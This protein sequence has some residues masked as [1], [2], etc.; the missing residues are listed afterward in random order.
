MIEASA[1]NEIQPPNETSSALESPELCVEGSTNQLVSHDELIPSSECLDQC[2]NSLNV[3]NNDGEMTTSDI[4]IGIFNLPTCEVFDPWQFE[5]YLPHSIPKSDQPLEASEGE[6]YNCYARAVQACDHTE[7]QG[8]VLEILAGMVGRREDPPPDL[9]MNPASPIASESTINFWSNTNDTALDSSLATSN[10]ITSSVH[11]LLPGTCPSWQPPFFFTDQAPYS[12]FANDSLHPIE[13]WGKTYKTATHLFEAL[14]Y[15]RYD[16]DRVEEIRGC[17]NVEEVRKLSTKLVR[18]G[19]APA[20]WESNSF[21]MIQG[22]LYAKFT[23]HPSLKRLL[24]NTPNGPL[25]YHN[26]GDGYWGSGLDGNGLNILG[27]ALDVVKSL[28]REHNY[29]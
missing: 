2:F 28:L 11:P 6:L 9:S 26:L 23:Q 19:K 4:E 25:I 15:I 17:S 5:D 10:T 20:D 22:I 12:G 29:K 24:L 1:R 27:Q 16:S 7:I 13:Y 3:G 21:S 14:K 8:D 18:D